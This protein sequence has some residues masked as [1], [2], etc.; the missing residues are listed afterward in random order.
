M[1]K[2]P[3]DTTLVLLVCG[4]LIPAT[5]AC[6]S[7]SARAPAPSETEKTPVTA[8]DKVAPAPAE[9]S[10]AEARELERI[11]Q[12][13]LDATPKAKTIEH[14]DAEALRHKV[15]YAD[16]TSH[17]YLLIPA[18]PSPAKAGIEALW[19]EPSRERLAALLAE[20][21]N[22]PG[23][24]ARERV[25]LQ[26]LVERQPRATPVRKGGQDP[27]DTTAAPEPSRSSA[28]HAELPDLL[29][30]HIDRVELSGGEDGLLP[31]A[32]RTDQISTRSLDAEQRRA[33]AQA[34]SALLLRADY[35]V[36][37]GVRGL[38][39]LQ[40]LTAALAEARNALVH[41]PD[42]METHAPAD[43]RAKRY[44]GEPNNV[45]DQVVILPFIERSESGAAKVRL[46]TRGMR[47]FG[48][49]D[50][51][52][53]GLPAAPQ[54]L[55][56][57]TQWM[58][59]TASLLVSDAGVDE[60]GYAREVPG[61]IVV[62]RADLRNAYASSPVQF[63]DCGGCPGQ[64]ELHLVERPELPTDA[65]DHVVAQIVAPRSASAQPD[66]D[67]GQWLIQAL[68]SLFGAGG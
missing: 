61:E 29:G 13:K 1:T 57:A 68:L 39:L 33:L 11:A 42:T 40:A 51:E 3:V 67:H 27:A 50:L 12:E 63:P 54:L 43:F 23:L 21:R 34:D 55:Q 15:V 44:L 49:V 32:A 5:S 60:S 35:R 59:G 28:N 45:A 41:D 19:R 58:H 16:R 62:A 46:T 66:H 65:I 48:V 31:T 8:P 52:L 36:A 2:R 53:A 25:M 4:W 47:R 64:I 38:R 26:T 6:N 18:G 20:K 7:K 10:E 30:F 17:G 37:E 22:F 24:Q 56:R 9:I 14:D